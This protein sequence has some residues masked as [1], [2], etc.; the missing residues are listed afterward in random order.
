MSNSRPVYRKV[1]N[2]QAITA[3]RILLHAAEED[4]ERVKVETLRVVKLAEYQEAIVTAYL[5]RLQQLGDVESEALA[6]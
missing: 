6:S 1:R 5:H 4:L 2:A 3:L